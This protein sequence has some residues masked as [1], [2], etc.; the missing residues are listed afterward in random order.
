VIVFLGASGP[1]LPHLLGLSQGVYRVGVS[2]GGA[3]LVS[4]PP[5][6]PGTTGPI[7]RGTAAR[8]PAPLADFERTVRSLAGA[9]R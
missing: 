6:M 1:R 7:V 4:P 5:V 8:R 3:A 2:A 9:G